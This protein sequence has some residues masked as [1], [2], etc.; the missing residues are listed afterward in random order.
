ML[1]RR[2]SEVGFWVLNQSIIRYQINES[3]LKM[4]LESPHNVRRMISQIDD[5]DTTDSD[6]DADASDTQ[7][8]FNDG[9]SDV[10][11]SDV[12]ST[13]VMSDE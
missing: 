7:N 5:A 3:L 4:I 11:S 12:D 2:H 13:V 8:L 6:S 1:W 9:S 10:D